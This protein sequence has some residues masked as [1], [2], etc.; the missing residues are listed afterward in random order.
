MFTFLCRL[1][2]QNKRFGFPP[3][4]FYNNDV[5]VVLGGQRSLDR[6]CEMKRSVRR[7]REIKV[8]FERSEGKQDKSL[9]KHFKFW[10]IVRKFIRRRTLSRLVSCLKWFQ[11]GITKHP[12]TKEVFLQR[13]YFLVQSRDYERRRCHLGSDQLNFA[14]FFLIKFSLILVFCFIIH[15]TKYTDK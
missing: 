4:K 15:M 9:T 6:P 7:K 2:H 10:W 13:K 5:I 11:S 3:K 14:I 12:F 8:Y 1:Q